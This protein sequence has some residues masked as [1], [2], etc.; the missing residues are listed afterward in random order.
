MINDGFFA[1]IQNIPKDVGL[2][3]ENL[4]SRE[5]DEFSAK[6]NILNKMPVNKMLRNKPRIHCAAIE[7]NKKEDKFHEISLVFKQMS[8]KR[9]LATSILI[10][11]K[12]PSIESRS[13]KLRSGRGAAR[14]FP[15]RIVAK[16]HVKCR[17]LLNIHLT[18][19]NYI[20][21]GGCNPGFQREFSPT[22][23]LRD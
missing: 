19:I 14:A 12:T 1:A 7:K 13:L 6:R 3:R 8:I 17:A 22:E 23:Y 5:N 9:T 20:L 10:S 16:C 21:S 2:M 15:C 18:R 4:I 11:L